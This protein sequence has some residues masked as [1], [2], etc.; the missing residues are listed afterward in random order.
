MWGVCCQHVPSHV[1]M[2]CNCLSVQQ[3]VEACAISWPVH[4]SPLAGIACGLHVHALDG[5]TSPAAP[6]T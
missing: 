2:H 3:L 6:A 4:L 5:S 1:A